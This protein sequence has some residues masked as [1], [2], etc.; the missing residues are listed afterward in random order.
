MKVLVFTN[1]K[2]G[3]SKTTSAKAVLDYMS[4]KGFKVLGIDLDSQCN[5]SYLS[6][7]DDSVM[8]IADIFK[9]NV[10]ITDCIQ[11]LEKYDFIASSKI[12]DNVA[13]LMDN[14]SQVFRLKKTL[15]DVKDIYDYV[16]IDTPPALSVSTVNALAAATDVIIP[17]HPDAFSLQGTEDLVQIINQITDV[18]EN[19]K[20][21]GILITR[22][23]ART[24]MS[25]LM[26]KNF[27][28]YSST[29]KTSIFNSMIRESVL[30]SE[31]QLNRNSI[32]SYNSPVT[33]DYERFCSELMER[34]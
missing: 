27:Q 19:I 26:S 4:G 11:N 33:E 1:K 9:D 6:K 14:V 32:F 16:V 5:L 3:C 28:L 18:N 31:S 2:G 22:Y 13:L 30:I 23:K 15:K 20:I 8:N 17:V 21:D 7:S 25:Q 29:L 34:L 10:P 24:N 12:V